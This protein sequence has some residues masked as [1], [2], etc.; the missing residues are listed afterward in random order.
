M[1]KCDQGKAEWDLLD[2]KALEK[3]VAVMMSGAQKYGRENWKTL[4]GPEDRRRIL[5]ALL[6]HAHSY[7]QGEQY[8]PE[9]GLDHMAHVICNA[10][11]LL[12]EPDGQEN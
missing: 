12:Y 5:N 10:M 6:R 3:A 9:S 4:N 2:Y 1:T 7:V 11:I 8:D